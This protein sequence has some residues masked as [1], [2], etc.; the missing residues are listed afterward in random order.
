MTLKNFLLLNCTKKSALPPPPF[1]FT[2]YLLHLTKASVC[3]KEAECEIKWDNGLG[4]T[5]KGF[6]RAVGSSPTGGGRVTLYVL[7]TS[8]RLSVA[9]MVPAKLSPVTIDPPPLFQ[10]IVFI[11]PLISLSASYLLIVVRV[12]RYS[13]RPPPNSNLCSFN[14]LKCAAQWAADDGQQTDCE[15]TGEGG[16]R[17]H[18][19]S[20]RRGRRSAKTRQ[21]RVKWQ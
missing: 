11:I 7:Q 1:S 14:G 12:L 13:L 19:A 2:F 16:G 6:E 21:E 9:F 15:G 4:R 18:R 20:N 17:W 5:P 8:K 3:K 10:V